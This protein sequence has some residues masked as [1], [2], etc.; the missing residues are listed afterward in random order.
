MD[1][2]LVGLM[3]LFFLTFGIFS[4]LVVFNKPITQ[5]TRAKEDFAP[6]GSN[7]IIIV[8]PLKV[9]ADGKSTA[10]ITIFVR[11][12]SDKPVSNKQVSLSSSL[13][14]IKNINEMSDKEGKVEFQLS[15][16]EKGI[17]EINAMIDESIEITQKVSVKFE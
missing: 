1:K 3:V 14:K 15:S 5:A 9:P 11:S 7:S 4:T 12:A 2:K 6:S 17:A 10:L 13:G 16:S 8:W